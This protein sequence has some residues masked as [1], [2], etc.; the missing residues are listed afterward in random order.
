MPRTTQKLETRN[1]GNQILQHTTAA[2]HLL[3][4]ITTDDGAAGSKNPYLKG[5]AGI[6]ILLLETVQVMTISVCTPIS[7]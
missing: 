6:S 5:I 4:N 3:L 2:A 1:R 7:H